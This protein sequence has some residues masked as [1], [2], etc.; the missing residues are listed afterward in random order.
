MYEI[1]YD[2]NDLE[3]ED[4]KDDDSKMIEG[5]YY[6]KGGEKTAMYAYSYN[7]FTAGEIKEMTGLELV[8]GE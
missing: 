4:Y 1:S 3:T 2:F 6:L 7:H 5:Y 8:V